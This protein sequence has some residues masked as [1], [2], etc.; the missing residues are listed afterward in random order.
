MMV[1]AATHHNPLE[2]TMT[3]IVAYRLKGEDYTATLVSKQGLFW[4][5]TNDEKGEHK[6][7]AKAVEETWEEGTDPVPPAA[8]DEPTSEAADPTLAADDEPTTA[9]QAPI[10][11]LA[12]QAAAGPTV[13]DPG[14][15]ITL[16]ELCAD[17]GIEPRIARRQLRAHAAKTPG[18][19]DPDAAWV[20][21]RTTESIEA[22]ML[23]I[24][25]RKR[26]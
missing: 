18:F 19:H 20:F 14:P 25:T 10:P 6:I 12:A 9:D 1:P 2:I 23:I 13:A 11:S 8:N 16:A 15:T 3:T 22:I 7:P 26:G 21:P 24:T 17:Q 5:V 4:T